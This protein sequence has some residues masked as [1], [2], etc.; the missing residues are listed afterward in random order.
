MKNTL[1]S[2]GLALTALVACNNSAGVEFKKLSSY[3]LNNFKELPDAVNVFTAQNDSA[4]YEVVG[5]AKTMGNKITVPDFSKE[6]AFIVAG[7]ATN[8]STTIDVEQVRVTAT[9]VI[10]D[11]K[12]TI[13]EELTY[14]IV[15]MIV[16]TM[17]KQNNDKVVSVMEG[18]AAVAISKIR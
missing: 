9:D 2:I 18:A 15:P 13:G 14:T 3:F 7:Q 17:P 4:F 10:I 5:I 1:L 16:F 11:I 6:T 12:I 8:Y